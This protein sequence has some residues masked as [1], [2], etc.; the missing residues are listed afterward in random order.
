MKKNVY[1]LVLLFVFSFLTIIASF[2]QNDS[3]FEDENEFV[4]SDEGNS[5][6]TTVSESTQKEVKGSFEFSLN[7]YKWLPIK[8]RLEAWLEGKSCPDINAT[9]CGYT[10][11]HANC[12][13]GNN[14]FD[15]LGGSICMVTWLVSLLMVVIY[16]F[17]IN[18]PSWNKL[19]NWLIMLITNSVIAFGVA[20]AWSSKSM[21]SCWGYH[22][23]GILTESG[24]CEPLPDI[25]L[26]D[27]L[28]FGLNNLLIA[29]LFFFVFSIVFKRFKA[30]TFISNCRNTPWI[31]K[32]PN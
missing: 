21:K 3:D 4:V 20:L 30:G 8:D 14:H 10:V 9:E 32:W 17:V 26:G 18:R 1:R 29:A 19:F 24:K 7:P 25:N 2:A 12:N 16:Y 31:T 28:Q 27:C 6:F 22:F 5:T 11:A 15:F 23:G 13:Q